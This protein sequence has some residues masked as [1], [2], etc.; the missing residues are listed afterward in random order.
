MTHDDEMTAARGAEAQR[1]YAE[2]GRAFDKVRERWT[3]EMNKAAPFSDDVMRLHA[4]LHALREAEKA[5][6]AQVQHGRV[7]RVALEG[8]G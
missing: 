3:A 5:M 8:V 6:I 4:Q 7:S 1:E 2:L